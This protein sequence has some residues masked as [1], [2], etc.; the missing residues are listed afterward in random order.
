MKEVL[1]A[2]GLNGTTL[3]FCLPK[4]NVLSSFTKEMAI[5][6]KI[7]SLGIIRFLH[8]HRSHDHLT[9]FS[10]FSTVTVI[11]FHKLLISI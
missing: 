8:K 10:T 7:M 3:S 1:I 6:R 9:N 11:F 4:K 2:L 5:G